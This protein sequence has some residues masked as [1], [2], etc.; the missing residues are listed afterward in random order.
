MDAKQ[1]DFFATFGFFKFPGLLRADITEIITAFEAVFQVHKGMIEATGA[2]T[3]APFIDH[4]ERLIALLADTRIASILTALVG[5][6]YNY[7]GSDG[8]Y[9]SGNTPWHPD[10]RD[11]RRHI[12]IAFYLDDLN[13]G[14]G[15]LRVI[16]GS[17]LHEDRFAGQL[18]AKLKESEL[19][20]DVAGKDIP[21]IALDVTPGDVLVFDQ[22]LQH[23]SWGGSQSRRMFTINAC[24]HYDDAEA[25][26]SYLSLHRTYQNTSRKYYGDLLLQQDNPQLR[27]HLQQ[28]LDNSGHLPELELN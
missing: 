6:D 9:Y 27:K 26:K 16:P 14:N 28:V 5:D 12:K 19:N 2:R 15:A 13:D 3:I 4:N 8:N 1:V 22:N 10:G 21:A 17:H 24:Q 25:F 20:W 11:Q 18:L 7:M 23:S